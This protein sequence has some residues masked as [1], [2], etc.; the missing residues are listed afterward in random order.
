MKGREGRRER[1]T[2]VALK[3]IRVN[4]EYGLVEPDIQIRVENGVI[5][6]VVAAQIQH[7]RCRPSISEV[8]SHRHS[9]RE[10]KGREKARRG[11]SPMALSPLSIIPTCLC[12]LVG[13]AALALAEA[14][15]GT[16]GGWAA[17]Q[18]RTSRSFFEASRPAASI[19][20]LV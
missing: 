15:C 19:G 11:N 8:T 1:K 17:I 9:R 4:E 7:V 16:A 14:Y 12:A 2:Y 13:P 20:E 5:R 18:S 6:H 10:G 3:L